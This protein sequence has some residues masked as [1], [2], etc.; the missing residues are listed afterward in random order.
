MQNPSQFRFSERNNHLVGRI[1]L[2]DP[3]GIDTASQDEEG[4]VD[5]AGFLQSVTAT[6]RFGGAFH[7]GQIAEG[8]HVDSRLCRIFSVVGAHNF[9]GE[10]AV[11][12]TRIV[13][14]FRRCKMQIL[15]AEEQDAHGI[16]GRF[17]ADFFQTY[18]MT[19]NPRI[20]LFKK[21]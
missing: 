8:H 16:V 1:L 19:L 2:I 13:I 20:Q 21:S 15:F 9:D 18:H 11:R 4:R 17:N 6:L 7:S 12:A 14:Q 10:D 5:V 3:H